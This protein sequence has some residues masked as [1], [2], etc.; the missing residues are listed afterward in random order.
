MAAAVLS[1]FIRESD[2]VS[3]VQLL[4]LVSPRS[5]FLVLSLYSFLLFRPIMDL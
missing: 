4:P 3:E 2:E 5:P 1:S